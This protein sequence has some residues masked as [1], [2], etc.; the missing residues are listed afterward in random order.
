MQ[1]KVDADAHRTRVPGKG[2]VS[3]LRQGFADGEWGDGHGERVFVRYKSSSHLP[4]SSPPH[5]STST[6]P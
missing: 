2:A 1:T 4:T 3:S 6:T 5:L